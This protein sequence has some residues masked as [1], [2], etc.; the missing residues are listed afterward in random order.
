[1]SSL[2]QLEAY[3]SE[4]VAAAQ[5]LTH[6]CRNYEAP[7]DLAAGDAPPPLVPPNAPS[8]VHRARRS[9]MASLA[10]LQTV[11]GE[12][13]DFVHQLAGQVRYSS[14]CTLFDPI[15]RANSNRCR[16][17]SSLVYNGW[18]SIRYWPV[19]PLAAAFFWRMLPILQAFRRRSSVV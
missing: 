19:Y 5:R 15:D 11:L 1:M 17:S 4:L 12:P 2:A 6:Y 3:T 10:K 18:A 8:E 13:E 7:V 14:L 9:M 16:I